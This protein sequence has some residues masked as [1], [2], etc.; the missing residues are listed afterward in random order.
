MLKH[1]AVTASIVGL[2]LAA[3]PAGQSG[4]QLPRLSDSLDRAFAP[5]G[6][7]HMSL[8]AG[9][10]RIAGAK[11]ERIHVLWNVRNAEDLP[12]VR[13][14]AN[15]K[16]SVATLTTDGVR[17]G[18]KADIQVP[19]RS[20][21]RVRLTAGDLTVEGIEGN[22]DVEL[23]AGDLTI[24]V[25][26]AEDYRRVDASLWAGD[27]DALPF[28]V[29]KGGLF[30]SFDWTGNGAYTLHAHLKAGDLRLRSNHPSGR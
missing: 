25:G 3:L 20:G 6:E 13:V 17:N 23:H 22:K 11:D 5:G 21:L 4:S 19:A 10:Y 29:S 12:Q 14:Q 24:D 1:S 30:R 28:N 26:R 2:M 7:V 27:L 9:D 8:S 15:V 18:F 16:G